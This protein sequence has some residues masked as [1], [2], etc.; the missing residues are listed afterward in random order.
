MTQR[1]PLIGITTSL[2]DGNQILDVRYADAVEVAGGLPVILPATSSASVAEEL[3]ALLDGLVITGG[4][5]ITTGLVGSLPVDIS[6]T[7]PRRTAS[8]GLYLRAHRARNAPLLGICYGMQMINAE[9]GG[10]IHADIEE[11]VDASLV[12]SSD[13][14]GKHHPISLEPGTWLAS[15]LGPDTRSVN[16]YHV[17]AL[18]DVGASLRVAARAPDGVIEAIE[19]EDGSMIGV[20]FHP[21][22]QLE[23]LLPV[24]EHLVAR[25]RERRS[26]SAG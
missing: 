5:A 1:S 8:D 22:R 13:R 24:F 26:L 23:D 15:I 10:T 7:D 17:Q 4:P 19:N 6:E 3:T 11:A 9:A 21:E 16:T 18:S 12:H 2:K 20:Q 14:G 25:A